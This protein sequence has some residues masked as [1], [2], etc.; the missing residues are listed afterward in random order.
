M[1]VQLA[2]LEGLGVVGG[3]AITVTDRVSALAEQAACRHPED[4]AR[5]DAIADVLAASCMRLIEETAR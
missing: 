4:R 3:A 2:R 5:T 1:L